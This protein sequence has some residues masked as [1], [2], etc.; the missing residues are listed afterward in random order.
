MAEYLELMR[1]VMILSVTDAFDVSI[2]FYKVFFPIPKMRSRLVKTIT[3]HLS[4]APPLRIPKGS[5]AR[6]VFDV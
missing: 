5:T 2:F 4:I 6:L 3:L 1:M